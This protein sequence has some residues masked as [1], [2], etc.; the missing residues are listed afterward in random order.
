MG[1]SADRERTLS[2]LRA[3]I[4][5]LERRSPSATSCDKVLPFAIP[6]LDRRLPGGGLRLGALHEIEPGGRALDHGAAAILFAAGIL[7]RLTGPVLWCLASRDLFAP[8]LARAGLHPDRVIY[9]ETWRGTHVLPLME[10]G[11]RCPGL[12][13]V[14][15]EIGALSLIGSRRLQLAAEATGVVVLA[16][17]RPRDEAGSDRAGRGEGSAA[18]TRW[19]IRALPSAPLATPGYGRPRWQV[20]LL[21]CRGAPA[22][23]DL[24]SWVL[25]GCDEA[26]RL[27]LPADLADGPRPQAYLERAASGPAAG[28]GR[29]RGLDAHRR[30]RLPG[31]AEGGASARHDAHP[32]PDAR[33]GPRH[34]GGGA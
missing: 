10:E 4:A 19:R 33:A 11:V 9:A 21:R 8:G 34:G 16:L 28:H 5:R 13:G 3:R 27:A 31:S 1:L 18:L 20:E 23:A 17:R 26:G 15:G 22:G 24:C 25:E 7:G 32:C 30:E 6:D 2:D 14:V 29:A 12:A